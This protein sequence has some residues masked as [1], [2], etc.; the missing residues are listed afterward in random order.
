MTASPTDDLASAE[1]RNQELTKE[2]AQASGELAEAREQ[3]ATTAEILRMISSSPL[4]L[5]R[6]FAGIAASA[7]NLCDAHDA[8]I[9]QADDDIIRVVA[10]YGPI[11][12]T[13]HGRPLKRGIV[14]AHAILDRR[15]IQ[16]PHLQAETDV[17]PESSELARRDG[18]R[19]LLAVPLIHASQAIGA[20][21][22][23]RIEVRP[24]S[25]KQIALLETFANQAVIAI[26]NTWLFEAE[27]ASK[28]EL[29]AEIQVRGR[30]PEPDPH[31]RPKIRNRRRS[32]APQAS[33]AHL[34]ARTAGLSGR[35]GHGPIA[36]RVPIRFSGRLGCSA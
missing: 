25:D 4:D 34:R 31:G 27:Q 6:V 19:S 29:Q 17:F 36:A 30:V 18:H 3:R 2:L 8:T 23:R 11:S 15:T 5:Q 35:R 9:F 13:A 28:R 14:T 21:T 7:A 12:S 16:V 10:H 32:F 24:F 22:I 33:Q 20:I 26:E 1:R